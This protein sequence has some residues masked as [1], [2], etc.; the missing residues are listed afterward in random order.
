LSLETGERRVE[1]NVL[2]T[3]GGIWLRMGRCDDALAQHQQALRVARATANRYPEVVALTG[4]AA[5]QAGLGTV[6]LSHVHQ[7]L[8][9]AG[10]VGYRML[11][12]RA[13]TVLAAI[14]LAGNRVDRCVAAAREALAI[15]RETGHRLGEARTLVI[16]GDALLRADGRD[17]AM[18]AWQ[19]SYAIFETAGVPEAKQVR[20]VLDAHAD[21]G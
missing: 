14:H 15:H 7:A 21:V 17:A 20:A 5:A 10:E 12:G 6:A 8:A 3:L 9:V 2:N 4:M 13:G 18:S 1:A 16:L 19:R 11:V